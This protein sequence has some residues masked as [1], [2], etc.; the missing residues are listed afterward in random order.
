[1]AIQSTPSFTPELLNNYAALQT[2]CDGKQTFD[3]IETLSKDREFLTRPSGSLYFQDKELAWI[4]STATFKLIATAFFAAMSKIAAFFCA[5]RIARYFSVLSRQMDREQLQLKSQRIF[6]KDLLVPAFN[7][8][9]L[10]CN[11]VTAHPKIAYEDIQDQQV[12]AMTFNNIFIKDSVQKGLE[13]F[14][15]HVEASLPNRISEKD[16]E[17]V[18]KLFLQTY[19]EKGILAAIDMLRNTYSDKVVVDTALNKLYGLMLDLNKQALPHTKTLDLYRENGICRGAS[20]WFLYLYLNTSHLFIDTET[21]LRAVAEQFKLGVPPQGAI[22]QA[23][24]EGSPLLRLQKEDRDEH[25][26]SILELDSDAESA[27]DKIKALLPGAYRLGVYKHSIVYIKPDGNAGYLFDPE[28]GL[29]D[30]KQSELLPWIKT[31]R[32]KKGD[33]GSTVRFHEFSLPL[34]E[35]IEE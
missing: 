33:E 5:P 4:H 12:R 7:D 31:H 8:H 17:E 26:I 18:E 16:K 19:Q 25:N 6:G 29:L 14:F 23:L 2:F 9:I 1:M 24:E 30:V 35:E 21:H 27:D 3:A 32:Y 11:S 15:L 20:L 34:L 22:S 28:T 10:E 13:P